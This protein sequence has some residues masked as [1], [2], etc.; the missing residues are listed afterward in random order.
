LD[1]RIGLI[2]DLPGEDFFRELS[3]LSI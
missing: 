1:I 2:I 3:A